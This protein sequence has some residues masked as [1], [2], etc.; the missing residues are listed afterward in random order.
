VPL[1]LVLLFGM[2]DTSS[3]VAI[4][5]KVTLTA[6]TLSDLVSQG[7]KVTSTDISNFFKMGSAV[8]TPWR[9]ASDHDAENH[10]AR[11]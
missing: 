4:D 7:S 9:H 5:R 8:M 6:R 3:G 1:M 10:A 11:R 2:I